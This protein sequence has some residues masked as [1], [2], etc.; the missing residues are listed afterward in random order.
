MS[1]SSLSK[2]KR[3][4]L[5]A[6]FY[7][8]QRNPDHLEAPWYEAWDLALNEFIGEEEE[9]SICPQAA[10][11][12]KKTK[13]Y[14]R[15]PDFVT[16]L[17]T[18]SGTSLQDITAARRPIIIIE[19]KPWL[20]EYADDNDKLEDYFDDHRIK[21]QL[22]EQAKFIFGQSNVEIQAN[23]SIVAV[24]AV[25]HMWK[26]AKMFA[27]K[28][29]P[30]KPRNIPKNSPSITFLNWSSRSVELG[31]SSSDKELLKLKSYL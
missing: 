27:D 31:T 7:A 5:C 16:Y 20:P 1:S 18:S 3:K 19:V 24:L 14:S 28:T 30:F 26:C 10:L 2:Y 23:T 8:K 22:V 13:T 4:L 6:I 9:Y 25:G 29:S 15:Y 17:T 12:I 11:R 21:G